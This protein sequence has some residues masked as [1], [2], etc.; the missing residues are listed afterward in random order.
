[1]D[2]TLGF[3]AEIHEA[4]ERTQGGTPQ[5]PVQ[6]TTLENGRTF[7]GAVETLGY[8]FRV[9][10]DRRRSTRPYSGFDRRQA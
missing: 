2:E 6:V 7:G 3:A 10:P 4:Q 1:M 8:S 9:K 5:R